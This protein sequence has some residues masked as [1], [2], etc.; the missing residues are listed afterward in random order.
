MRK[1][2][3]LIGRHAVADLRSHLGHAALELLDCVQLRR[4]DGVA[5]P[6]EELLVGHNP[7]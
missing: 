7:Y 4:W 5:N 3:L 2:A 6:R 1:Q